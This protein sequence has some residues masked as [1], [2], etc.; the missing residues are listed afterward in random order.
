M[1]QRIRLQIGENLN[2][3]SRAILIRIDDVESESLKVKHASFWRFGFPP[4]DQTINKTGAGIPCRESDEC[5]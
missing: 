2:F 4:V 1:Q 3:L 5:I